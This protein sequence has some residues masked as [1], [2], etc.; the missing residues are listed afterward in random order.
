MTK[1]NSSDPLK[2]QQTAR[3]RDILEGDEDGHR[4]H[5]R[6]PAP[7]WTGCR[8]RRASPPPRLPR[9]PRLLA[10]THHPKRENAAESPGRSG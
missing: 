8:A 5:S 2:D 1:P 7:S 3:F 9:Q 10:A 4:T 6:P